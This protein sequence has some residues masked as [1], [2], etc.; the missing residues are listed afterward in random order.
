MTWMLALLGPLVLAAAPI[1]QAPPAPTPSPSA[2]PSAAPT[3]A[4]QYRVGAG[5][6]LEVTVF[7]NE[8]LS[9]TS[10]V[11]PDGTIHLPLL[12]EVQ[13]AGLTVAEVQQKLTSLLARDYLVN[14]QIDVK[15]REYQSQV[16]FLVGEVNS[17][18]R[19][20]LRGTTRLIDALVEAGGFTTRAS[21]EIAITRVDGTFDGGAKTLRMR[22]G[23]AALTPQ[24]QVN[25]AVPLRSGDIV[26][27]SPKNYVTVEG[28]VN[29]PGRYVL[30]G[31]LTVTGAVS[32][33]GG[34]TRFGS[35]KVK[36]RRVS[37]ETAVTQILEADL[38]AIR[39]G[40]KPDLPLL[41]NDVVSISRRLF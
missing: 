22:L 41:P 27:A 3:P 5:D 14:P 21:G 8:D 19:K 37:P 40:K 13:V 16:V 12:G 32:L 10:T 24:D 34:L 33:A 2:P 25:L 36:V 15:V 9:R 20:S 38:K 1:P 39:K 29:H 26:T 23:S 11:Q 7:G 30:D 6:V 31:E 4:P 28:E 17:P 35:S 18:G